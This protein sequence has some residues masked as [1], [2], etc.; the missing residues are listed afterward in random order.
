M[1]SKDIL[2]DDMNVTRPIFLEMLA[3]LFIALVSIITE[4]GDIVSKCIKPYVNNVSVIEI[5]GD[6]PFKRRSGSLR[7]QN[8]F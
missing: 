7:F 8:V 5:Y 3:L 6:S 2:T 1:E 4:R